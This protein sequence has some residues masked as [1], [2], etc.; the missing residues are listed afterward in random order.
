MNKSKTFYEM[1]VLKAIGKAC[2]K[3]RREVLKLTQFDVAEELFY[4]DCNIRAFENGRNDNATILAWFMSEGLTW[5]DIKKE[6]EVLI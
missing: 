5:D 6:L 1:E 2:R 4:S 3:Y